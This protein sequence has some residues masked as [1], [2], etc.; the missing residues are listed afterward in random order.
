MDVGLSSDLLMDIRLGSNLVMDIG[1]GSN[2]LM[3]IGL[4]LN[5]SMDIGLSSRIQL[6]I[7]NR[8]IIGLGIDSSKR[9]SDGSSRLSSIGYGS[10]SV[11]VSSNSSGVAIGMRVGIASIGSW[12][13][14]SRS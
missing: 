10:S 12:N 11:V 14:T 6:S 3:D 1:L 7:G 5:L 13:K 4:S 8:G 9:S 2:F